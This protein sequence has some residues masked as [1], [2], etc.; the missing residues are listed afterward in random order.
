MPVPKQTPVSRQPTKREI[1][2]AKI[3]FTLDKGAVL[4]R[5]K[6]CLLEI[7]KT[8]EE[9][10]ALSCNKYSTYNI[11][12]GKFFEYRWFIA[13]TGLSR[14]WIGNVSELMKYM[15]KTK[16]IIEVE[17]INGHTESAKCKQAVKYFDVAYERFV[18]SLEKPVKVSSKVQRKAKLEKVIWQKA[19]RKKYK[20]KRECKIFSSCKL[21]IK[22][23]F[24]PDLIR[25]G[26]F[27]KKEINFYDRNRYK[28]IK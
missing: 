6:K 25:S 2:I 17:T 3:D 14:K 4:E 28:I 27:S 19:M 5:L 15:E 20:I 16:S 11:I 12:I 9:G 10:K 23:C 21:Q 18:K 24:P 7:Q 26:V 1:A 22:Q 13:D 8:K